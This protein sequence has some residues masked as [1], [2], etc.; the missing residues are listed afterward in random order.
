[1]SEA[2]AGFFFVL[3]EELAVEALARKQSMMSSAFLESSRTFTRL[4]DF[5]SRSAVAGSFFVGDASSC[6][7]PD[8]R[9]AA[10]GG[11][12]QSRFHLLRG[13]V[14]ASSFFSGATLTK[15]EPF[16]QSVGTELCGHGLGGITKLWLGSNP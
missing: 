6:E 15:G 7:R 13:D 1:M 10:C 12:R 16:P 5:G 8:S 11:E 3:F 4:A 9:A 2:A 14:D